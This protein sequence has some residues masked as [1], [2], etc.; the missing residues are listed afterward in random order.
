MKRGRESDAAFCRRVLPDLGTSGRILVL[1]DEAH[2]AY[3]FPPDL[4][5]DQDDEELR[6]ATVWI[7]GLERI[8][9]QRGILRA[10]DCS[11]TPMYPAP[12]KDRA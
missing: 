1:N 12:F 3:R 5:A 4:V 11:A 2:H 7:E 9:R 8:N 10:I 6:E